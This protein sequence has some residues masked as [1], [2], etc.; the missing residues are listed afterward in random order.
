LG[1]PN[2]FAPTAVRPPTQVTPSWKECERLAAAALEE[3][4]AGAGG[5]GGA[6]DP[7]AV[8]PSAEAVAS[9]AVAALYEGV[10]SG[11]IQLGVQYLF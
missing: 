4:G 11:T 9:S 2:R 8:E 1:A 7:F 3:S 10:E 6:D 5:K